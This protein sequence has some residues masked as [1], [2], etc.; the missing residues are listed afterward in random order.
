VFNLKKEVGVHGHRDL[1]LSS[2][3]VGGERR[4][5][6]QIIEKGW[7]R[8]PGWNN[9]AVAALEDVYMTIER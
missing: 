1:L 4:R 2:C 3:D 7:S 5:M 8:Q 6:H 9:S